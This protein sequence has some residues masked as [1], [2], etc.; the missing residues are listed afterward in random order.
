MNRSQVY[1]FI[2]V[3]PIF[4]DK[5]FL[6][7]SSLRIPDTLQTPPVP[8]CL[9]QLHQAHIPQPAAHLFMLEIKAVSSL[10]CPRK[11]KNFPFPLL[12]IPLYPNLG[13]WQALSGTFPPALQ[14]PEQAYVDEIN[15]CHWWISPA[16]L[17]QNY[18]WKKSRLQIIRSSS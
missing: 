1:V 18:M 4:M 13:T 16:K 9:P 7:C 6:F 11:W 14:S 8:L 15:L 2:P 12:R 5:Y 17:H 3:L 10:F